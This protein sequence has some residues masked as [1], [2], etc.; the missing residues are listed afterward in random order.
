MI[1][2]NIEIT[3]NARGNF[4]VKNLFDKRLY[5]EGNSSSA[6]AATYNEPGRAIHSSLTASF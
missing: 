5:R 2:I 1:I 4:G 6:G 3:D